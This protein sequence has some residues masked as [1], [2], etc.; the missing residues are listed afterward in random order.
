M[1]DDTTP[2]TPCRYCARSA[3][4]GSDCCLTCSGLVLHIDT[5][6]GADAGLRRVLEAIAKRAPTLGNGARALS[7]QTRL[8]LEGQAGQTGQLL[9]AEVLVLQSVVARV[10]TLKDKIAL[11]D[12]PLP[13]AE[14]VRRLEDALREP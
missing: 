4:P 7:E 6:V 1:T 3:Y 2:A 11:H 5:F 9:A 8:G 12:A 13:A 14:V 10:R